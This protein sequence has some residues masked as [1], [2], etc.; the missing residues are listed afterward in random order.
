MSVKKKAVKD[1]KT[2]VFV[3][4]SN[5][6]YACKYSC[7]FDLDFKKYYQY[8]QN[9]YANLQEVR[10]Y[11]GVASDDEKKQ[12][13]FRWLE[14]IGYKVCSLERKSYTNEAKYANFECSECGTLNMVQILPETTKLKS[15]VDV[16]MA[17]DM[18]KCAAQAI[19]P[20]HIILVTCDGDF[21]EA[22]YGV[23]AVKPNAFVT[24]MATPMTR[25]KNCLSMRLKTLRSKLPNEM[26][27]MNIDNLR[28]QISH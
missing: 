2:F 28:E 15:N 9:K 23:L 16:Y 18:L 17:A 21:T 22:I 20:I 1:R 4:V 11:E 3:D 25:T 5:I 13:Y 10:Y 19:E 26:A 24:V 6:R 14:K 27:L 8:L 12:R 7:E